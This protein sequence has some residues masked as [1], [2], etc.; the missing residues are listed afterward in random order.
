MVFPFKNGFVESIAKVALIIRNY[1]KA[2][3][4]YL[5]RVVKSM[6]LTRGNNKV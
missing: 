1:S 2:N 4:Y 6:M 5:S 3:V